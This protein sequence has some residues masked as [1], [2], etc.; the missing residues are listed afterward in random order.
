MPD[1][2]YGR[3]VSQPR[4]PGVSLHSRSEQVIE[5]FT[6]LLKT[7]RFLETYS[8]Q[9]GLKPTSANSELK[10]ISNHQPPVYMYL[11]DQPLTTWDAQHLLRGPA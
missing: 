10:L 3:S 5:S 7:Y 9:F 8:M 1:T 11:G 4:R 6:H 2:R